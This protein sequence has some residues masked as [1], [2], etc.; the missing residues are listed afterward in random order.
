MPKKI[1]RQEEAEIPLFNSHTEAREWFKDRY[2]DAFMLTDSELVGTE[3]CYFYYLILDRAVFEEEVKKLHSGTMTDSLK[4]LNSYQNI[5]IMD[6]GS[7]HI[8]H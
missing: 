2:G 3:I 1:T 7:V 5:Q 8:V 6:G 4:F